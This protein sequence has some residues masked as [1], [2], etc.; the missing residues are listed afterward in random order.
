[1]KD[2]KSSIYICS[3]VHSKFDELITQAIQKGW[4]PKDKNTL[5]VL[6]GNIIEATLPLPEVEKLAIYIHNFI[7]KI[8]T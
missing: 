8:K 2:K 5:L 3:D 6:A 4:K 1:M 7:K